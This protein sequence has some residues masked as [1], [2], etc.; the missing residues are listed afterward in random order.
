[1]LDNKQIKNSISAK[2]TLTK[3][4]AIPIF[5]NKSDNYYKNILNKIYNILK[6]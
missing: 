5:L 1:M 6:N 3:N 2:K 4:I